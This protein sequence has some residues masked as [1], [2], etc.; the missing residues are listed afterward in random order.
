MT[1]A[2]SGSAPLSMEASCWTPECAAAKER[3]RLLGLEPGLVAVPDVQFS[4]NDAT[5]LMLGKAF[6]CRRAVPVLW[7]FCVH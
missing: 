1:A 7:K 5:G 2:E 3:L 6:D 4:Y